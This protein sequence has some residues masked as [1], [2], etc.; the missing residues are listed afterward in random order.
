M[1]WI[2]N[3]RKRLPRRARTLDVALGALAVI[4]AIAAVAL[5]LAAG[6]Y[7]PMVDLPF[8]AAQTAALRH[9]L[10]PSFHFREQ[11]ELRPFAVPYLS[12][13]AAGALLMTVLPAVTAVKMA[14]GLMLLLLP[15]GLAVMLHGMKKSPLLGLSGLLAVWGPLTHWGFLNF[16]GAIG[17]FAM[18]VGLSL[19]VVERPTRGGLAALGL[20]LVALFFTHVF[21]YPFAL[22]AVVGAGLVAGKGLRG[23]RAVAPAALPALGLFGAWM[24]LRPASLRGGLGPLTVDPTRLGDLV[25]WLHGSFS[26]PGEPRALAFGAATLA[27]VASACGVAGVV[28][29]RSPLWAG[30]SPGARARAAV[31]A[32]GCAGASLLLFITLPMQIGDWW[33]VYPREATAACFLALALLPDLPRSGVL[34]AALVAATALASMP[35]VALV[36][37]SYAA[38]DDATRD[39]AAIT[40]P[41][42]RGPKLLYLIFDHEGSNRTTSPFTHLPAYVQAELGGSLS[43]HFAV[44]GASPLAYRPREGRESIVPPPTPPRWESTPQAFDVRDRGRFFDWFLVRRADPPDAL[45]AADPAI[46]LSS[47]AGLW[48]L[49]RRVDGDG[50]RAS[51]RAALSSSSPEG[52]QL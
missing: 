13:Y 32:L 18:V 26:D 1:S 48:W 51:G 52:A 45:F 19:L 22:A 38:F 49:Y 27:V 35:M 29:R 10:D 21:R 46:V 6:R 34:R 33:Y 41:L 39:F 30:P 15:A 2:A 23:L 12:M 25:D 3:A 14:A 16:L 8:H 20:A 24:A 47:H 17:L 40:R 36:T 37:R 11:F 50:D 7:P 5:P 31:V 28:E 42:P 9:Y 43:Y 4:V 44:Y